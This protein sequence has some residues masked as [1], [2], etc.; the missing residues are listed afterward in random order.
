MSPLPNYNKFRP[1]QVAS[2]QDSIIPRQGVKFGELPQNDLCLWL[3]FPPTS[4]EGPRVYVR[5]RVRVRVRVCACARAC[6]CVCV[7]LVRRTSRSSLIH[8]REMA[9]S[10][11]PGEGVLQDE[12]TS[13]DPR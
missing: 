7:C 4:Y 8:Q 9:A 2:D 3:S 6:G 11:S 1:S 10:L 12:R 5:A 13:N